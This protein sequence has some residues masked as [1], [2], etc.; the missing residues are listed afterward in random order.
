MAEAGALEVGGHSILWRLAPRDDA[1][2]VA[3][4]GF[5]PNIFP[6]S[7]SRCAWLMCLGTGS[8]PH[9]TECDADHRGFRRPALEWTLY[10]NG[11]EV[12]VEKNVGGIDRVAR[13]VVGLGLLSLLFL[14]DGMSRWWGLAGLALLGTG[15]SGWCPAYIPFGIKTC[16]TT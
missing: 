8:V 4:T 11:P 13:I 10:P 6:G 15:L 2:P 16:K 7:A 1:E 5:G 3:R 12:V 9:H 14:L